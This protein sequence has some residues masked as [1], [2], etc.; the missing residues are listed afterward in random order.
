[1]IGAVVML[2]MCM[3]ATSRPQSDPTRATP[4]AEIAAPI[5]DPP[6]PEPYVIPPPPPPPAPPTT[7]AIIQTALSHIAADATGDYLA[8]NDRRDADRA[9]LRGI[10]EPDRTTRRQ[11]IRDTLRAVDQRQR[12][13]RPDVAAARERVAL[14]AVCGYSPPSISPWDGELV[15]SERY[16]RRTAHD[17]DSV[18]VGHCTTPVLT[19]RECWVS[20]CEVRGRNAF[21][22]VVMHRVRFSVGRQN[23]I[24]GTS[25]AY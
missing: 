24:L 9:A 20:V 4:P 1:V 17:P 13:M 12:T 14:A 8:H 11:Q 18:D 10:G 16:I 2:G 3:A 15:G 23:E 21:G 19:R 22:A 7:D 25:A 5:L 6:Q